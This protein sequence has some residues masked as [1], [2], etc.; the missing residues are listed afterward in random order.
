MARQVLDTKKVVGK[1]CTQYKLVIDD[2]VTSFVCKEKTK[3]GLIKWYPFRYFEGGLP[4][5]RKYEKIEYI[6]TEDGLIP[7]VGF[8]TTIESGYG[9]TRPQGVA[10][11][12]RYL[13][14]CVDTLEAVI[15]TKDR[16]ELSGGVLYISRE[17][18]GKLRARTK[19]FTDSTKR[20]QLRVHQSILHKILPDLFDEPGDIVYFEGQLARFMSKYASDTIRLGKDERYDK[21]R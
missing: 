1:N 16:S 9:F 18:F 13:E 19:L 12:F 20:E 4:P 21:A 14:T 8:T 10:Q 5:L 6:A 3:D 11:L 2:K 17:D 15:F 7:R